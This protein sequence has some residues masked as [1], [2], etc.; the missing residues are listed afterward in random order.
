MITYKG[1]ATMLRHRAKR[2]VSSFVIFGLAIVFVAAAAL[3]SSA[4]LIN[5]TPTNGVNS[6]TAV[7]SS[8]ASEDNIMNVPVGGGFAYAYKAFIA[9]VRGGWTATFYN[10]LLTNDV[11]QSGRLNHW[12]FGGQAGFMF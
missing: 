8:F 12:N 11:N 1:I 5:L 10:D 2:I 4:A 6:N 9:D 7:L 3:P